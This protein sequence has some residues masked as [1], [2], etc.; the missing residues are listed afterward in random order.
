M[1]SQINPNNINGNYP[2]AGV[3]NNSQ[4]FRDNF[5]NTKVNFQYAAE[6]IDDLQNK[7]LLKAALSGE[8]LDNDFGVFVNKN[9]HSSS[10][11]VREADRTASGV[12]HGRCSDER[13]AQMGLQDGAAF[14]GV[15][16]VQSQ[17]DRRV[18]G[19]LLERT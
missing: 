11:S 3:D 18:N 6:E 14:D 5:T 2:V 8:T 12:Q 17:H 7:V 16:A 9:T 13:G 15:G 19:D 4:G 10:L 1:T